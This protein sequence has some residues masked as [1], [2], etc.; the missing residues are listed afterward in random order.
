M[1]PE[2]TS[3]GLHGDLIEKIAMVLFRV[4]SIEWI[5][6]SAHGFIFG[7][8]SFGIRQWAY[9]SQSSSSTQPDY[10]KF[11]IWENAGITLSSLLL[12]L[13]VALILWKLALPM[14]RVI[15]RSLP[16]GN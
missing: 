5:F 15:R 11:F 13:I 4:V 7:A 3:P 12:N 10:R 9:L 6:S 2:S 1:I 16:Q 8:L 14:A